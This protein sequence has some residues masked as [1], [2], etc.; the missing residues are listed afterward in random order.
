MP[1]LHDCFSADCVE[2]VES[3]NFIANPEQQNQIITRIYSIRSRTETWIV[4]AF[5]TFSTQSAISGPAPMIPLNDRA[6]ATLP[7]AEIDHRSSPGPKPVASQ[8]DT[9][10]EFRGRG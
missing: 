7:D 9:G 10:P 1:S 3:G 6:E 4:R 8:R 2:K 5:G